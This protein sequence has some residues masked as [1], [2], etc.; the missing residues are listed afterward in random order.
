[1]INGDKYSLKT[2]FWSI[3]VLYYNMLLGFPPFYFKSH[4]PT[5]EE[6]LKVINENFEKIFTPNYHK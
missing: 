1:M 2:D 4:H 5:K 3:G 6:A